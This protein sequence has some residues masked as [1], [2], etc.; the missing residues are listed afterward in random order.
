MY[1][2]YSSLRR[3]SATKNLAKVTSRNV[4]FAWISEVTW[5]P[6]ETF[7]N[8]LPGS[9]T[10]TWSDVHE[11]YLPLTLKQASWTRHAA[12]ACLSKPHSEREIPIS[13]SKLPTPT[14]MKISPATCS[15]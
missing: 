4:T 8:S 5:S 14:W 10:H 9:F 3:I 15:S 6:M 7:Q 1:G 12:A 11:V 13:P 2:G